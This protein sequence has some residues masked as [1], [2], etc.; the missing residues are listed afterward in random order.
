[1]AATQEKTYA[2]EYELP[3]APSTIGE[4]K[5]LGKGS[6][7]TVF[8]GK[9]NTGKYVAIKEITSVRM[10]KRKI[11][12]E[13]NISKVLGCT[14]KNIACL[15]DV[16]TKPGRILLVSEYIEGP[17]L[18]QYKKIFSENKFTFLDIAYQLTDGLDYM[19][20]KKVVHR[21][22]KPQNIIMRGDVPIYIDFDMACLIYSPES[23]YKCTG[24][25]GTPYFI[26]PE[27]WN[28]DKD[29]NYQWSDIYSLGVT[30]YYMFNEKNHPF[31]GKDLQDLKYNVLNTD[32][33]PSD[34]G[35]PE[36]DDL[37]MSMISRSPKGRPSLFSIQAILSG[38]IKNTYE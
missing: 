28:T 27:N 37:I 6:F 32:P 21:D 30:F 22:I 4:P 18:D 33:V 35:I 3:K 9:D 1:M 34:C 20:R 8:L 11:T 10:K 24:H 16:V 2:I 17:T 15:L 13:I 36:L 26:S 19:W 29:I 7:G 12:Q 38:L 23:P 25:I 31:D 5:I 14:H